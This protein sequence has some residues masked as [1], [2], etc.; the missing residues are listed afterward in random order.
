M[1]YASMK[2]YKVSEEEVKLSRNRAIKSL[3]AVLMNA[4]VSGRNG[5]VDA[6]IRHFN[7]SK[8]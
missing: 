5:T 2:R 7:S 1:K 8:N 6:K 4:Y 3:K